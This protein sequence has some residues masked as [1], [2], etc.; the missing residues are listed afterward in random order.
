[1]CLD[2]CR[3]VFLLQANAVTKVTK[4]ALLLSLDKICCFLNFFF[5][6]KKFHFFHFVDFL[7]FLYY[8]GTKTLEGHLRK[9]CKCPYCLTRISIPTWNTRTWSKKNITKFCRAVP[10]CFILV[11]LNVISKIGLS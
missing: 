10:F 5:T 1:M 11:I 4:S 9:I 2:A 8:I 3:I 7:K 6:T